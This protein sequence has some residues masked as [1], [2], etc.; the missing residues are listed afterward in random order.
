MYQIA[1]RKLQEAATK[2]TGQALTEPRRKHPKSIVINVSI[3]R[4][5]RE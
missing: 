5:C 3:Q 1:K 2:V 4:T